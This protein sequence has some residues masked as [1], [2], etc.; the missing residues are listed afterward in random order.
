MADSAAPVTL[1]ADA[2]AELKGATAVN[3]TPWEVPDEVDY[4][5]LVRDFGCSRI[6]PE[7]IDRIEKLTGKAPHRFL[8]RGIFFTHRDLEK[9][10]DCYEKKIPFYL[11]TG[12]GPSSDSMHLGHLVPFLFTKYLQE[13]FDVPLVIQMTDD[14]KFLFRDIEMET[15]KRMTTENVKDVIAIGFNPKK[16]F[17]FSNFD[18]VGAMY[19][20][21]CKI[22][23]LITFNQVRGTF[24]FGES[25]NIGRIAFPAI[26]AAPS[27]SGAFPHMFGAHSDLYCLIPQAIDQDPYFRM[28]RDIAPR[29]KLKKPSL[30][31]SVFFPALTGPKGKMS[32][33]IPNSGV[34][35]TDTPAQIKNKINRFAF[36]G[37]AATVDE[38]RANGANIDIDVSYQWLR[39]FLDDDV[40][41]ARIA[42]DYASGRM[43]TSE[44]KAILIETITSIVVAHQEARK[45]VTDDIV[46]S[47]MAVRDDMDV[48]PIPDA[49]R[50]GPQSGKKDKKDGAG[51]GRAARKAAEA[52][53]KAAAAGGAAE[54]Q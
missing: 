11:Y 17:I 38:Q 16:T 36:S 19:P 10:L 50:N 34:F 31:H 9:V 27:F 3:V 8:R 24:G 21:V 53:A 14:E 42:D 22:Q 49:A 4:D 28:T 23:R 37:G 6:T 26:Q 12:R 7:L 30:M 13:A 18:Y 39:F 41:L 51:G 20:V 5:K 2:P 29:L 47:F 32:A 52:L 35:L 43:L 40:E 25:D 46:A 1:P 44:I 54:T 48:P 15:V 33:S 45:A